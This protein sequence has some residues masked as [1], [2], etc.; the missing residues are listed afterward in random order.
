MLFNCEYMLEVE[1][2]LAIAAASVANA[3][4]WDMPE[5]DEIDE[6]DDDEDEEEFTE[7]FL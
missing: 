2:E 7:P 5:V 6:D 1:D 3:V 4:F